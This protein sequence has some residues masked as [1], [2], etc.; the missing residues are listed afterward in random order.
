MAS[1]RL[2][3]LIF[4]FLDS[5]FLTSSDRNR[6]HKA[7][8]EWASSFLLC[9]LGVCRKPT[10]EDI[11]SIVHQMYKKDGLSRGDIEDIVDAFPDQRRE[12]G[13]NKLE[14]VEWGG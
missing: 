3:F 1:M 13:Q 12:R 14:L 10:R 8:R 9:R 5:F 11:V 6:M 4:Y 2:R 7:G